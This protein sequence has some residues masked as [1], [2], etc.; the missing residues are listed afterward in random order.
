MLFILVQCI[1]YSKLLKHAVSVY[2]QGAVGED[3][4]YTHKII[5]IMRCIYGI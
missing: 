1:H 5:I 3:Q 2:T 4:L